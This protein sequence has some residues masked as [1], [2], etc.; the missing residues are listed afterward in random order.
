MD[1]LTYTVIKEIDD[2]ESHCADN[3]TAQCKNILS[4]Q[5]GDTIVSKDFIKNVIPNFQKPRESNISLTWGMDI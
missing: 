2:V 5:V 1:R 4:T 3:V